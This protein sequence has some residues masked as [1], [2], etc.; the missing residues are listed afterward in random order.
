MTIDEDHTDSPL[1]REDQEIGAEV[2]DDPEAL[3]TSLP[4]YYRGEVTQVSSAQDRI[5][6]TT[7][8]AIT[9]LVALLSVVFSSPDMPA[10]LLLVALVALSIFL[11]YEVRRY[12]FYD[13]YRAR[14]RFFQENV[15][16]NA[17]VPL[18]V[19]H[20]RW[21]EELSD[22]LRYPTFKVTALEALSRRLRRI[23]VLLFTV[24]GVGWVAKVT[25][26]TPETQ[27]TEAAE[28]YGVPGHVI[29]GFLGLFYIGI[30]TLA[31]WPKKRQAKGEIYG[32]EPG[33]WKNR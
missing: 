30:F 22:D 7:N 12:R 5:D 20:P 15:F 21:R 25:L 3:L 16:A 29:A 27:W 4:H 9:V 32:E 1:D 18:G 6:Q 2:A 10:Y 24:V 8:W 26:F 13:M 33:D 23:Y 11:S 31:Q 17:L 28:I 14:V 19:E